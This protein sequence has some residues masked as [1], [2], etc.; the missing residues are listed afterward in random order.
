VA[1]PPGKSRCP[2]CGHVAL[3]DSEERVLAALVTS[4]LVG[5]SALEV[6]RVAGVSR[7]RRVLLVLDGL[8][9]AQL[10]ER[11][12]WAGGA[13]R[14]LYRASAAGR[15]ACMMLAGREAAE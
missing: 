13:P 4:G 10:V 1:R 7:A 14:R 2:C 12:R 11:Q 6:S 3:T 5:A 9:L 8:G 15:R